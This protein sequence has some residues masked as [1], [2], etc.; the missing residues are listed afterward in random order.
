MVFN[1]SNMLKI[2]ELSLAIDRL[3]GEPLG[4]MIKE[5]K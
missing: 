2:S 1:D 4:L 5:N 3:V